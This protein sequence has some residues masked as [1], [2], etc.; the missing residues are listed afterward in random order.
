MFHAIVYTSNPISL[1][2]SPLLLLSSSPCSSSLL[3]QYI[4]GIIRF[5]EACVRA[6]MH[7]YAGAL[8][9]LMPRASFPMSDD[10]FGRASPSRFLSA[11][12]REAFLG[13]SH[14]FAG[15]T[16][17]IRRGNFVSL[18][19]FLSNKKNMR[20][21]VCVGAYHEIFHFR[22]KKAS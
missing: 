7:E 6:R 3:T 9:F 19:G 10:A 22:N 21:R 8:S 4:P 5:K 16:G 2:L 14:S 12:R 1:S 13:T 17:F 15:N 18:R 20:A 11:W